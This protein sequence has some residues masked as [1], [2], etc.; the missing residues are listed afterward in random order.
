MNLQNLIPKLLILIII[1]APWTNSEGF[2]GTCNPSFNCGSIS[3]FHYPFRRHQ[4]PAQCGYPGFELNCDQQNPPTIN[5]MN[6]TYRVL[7][8]NPTAQTL[9][10]VRGDMV[11]SACPQ[12]LVNTTIDHELFDY[13]SSYTNISFLFG[14]PIPFDVVGMMGP[15]SCDGSNLAILVPGTL[16][17]GM[18]NTSVTIPFP[19]GLLNEN[20]F[21]SLTWLVPIFRDGFEVR[22]KVEPGPCT[23]CTLSGGQCVYDISR[24]G[25]TCAC[26]EPPLLGDSC[27]KVNRTRVNSSPSSSSSSSSS[28]SLSPSTGSSN[29]NSLAIALPIVGAVIVGVGIGWGIFVCRQRRKRLAI[30][31]SSPTQTESKAILTKYSTKV[32]NSNDSKFTSSIPPYPSP[33]TSETS[34][35]FG[36]SSYFGAQVFTYEELAVAT[37]NFN[38]S[39]ELGDG[40]FGA[41]YYGKLLDGREVAVKRLY[42]NSFRRVEQY[43][44]EVRILTGLDHEN[45]VKLYGCTSKQSKD[46]LLVYE[47]VSNGTVGDHLHGKLAKSS[48]SLFSW[49]VRF[50]IAIQTADALA[51]LHQSGIIHRDVKTNNILLDKSFQVKVADFGLS[52]LFQN[53]THVSTA[54]QGTPGY[55]DPEYYQCYHLTDKSDVYSFGVVLIELI[56]SLQAVDTNR[57]RLDINLANMAMT[58][59]QN[60]MLDELVD[61]S[62]G[63]E[64]NGV[65]RRTTAL[66]AEL[67]FRCLQQQKDMRPTM[68]EVAETLR[69]IRN[70]DLNAQKPEVVDVVVDDG[71]HNT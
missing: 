4:D 21:G 51:Y 49:P 50:S 22:W 38:D 67:A 42:E 40:G 12:D 59:I 52:R 32:P 56:S 37:D 1:K 33:R 53:V 8:L 30:N 47:Y 9:K 11:N 28:S 34:K 24:L 31:G 65:V 68:K 19:V 23:D 39:R 13:T 25:T 57:H 66:V 69:G 16:G 7:S 27:L 63:F 20:P 10:L 41:V 61:K 46:L 36:K 62:I 35:E 43:M 58:K 6:I 14:C 64:R 55:V 2:Y 54:P 17:P 15:L 5:I 18:C 48:T 29:S 44:N 26:P 71:G 3:G 45:L 60:H 70:D